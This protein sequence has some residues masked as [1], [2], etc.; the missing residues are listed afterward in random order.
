M[1]PPDWMQR[2]SV[3]D[4]DNL[5]ALAVMLAASTAARDAAERL[6]V[7]V[8]IEVVEDEDGSS[9]VITP[10]TIRAPIASGMRDAR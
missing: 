8:S 10:T 4:K 3:M 5:T 6:G 1:P 7:G 9:L 2:I